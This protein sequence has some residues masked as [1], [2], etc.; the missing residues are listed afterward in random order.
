MTQPTVV[1]TTPSG[2]EICYA[3]GAE[4]AAVS[5]Q[6]DFPPAATTV[7]TLTRST[8]EDETAAD[9][10]VDAEL[11]R[12]VAPT[13]IVTQTVCGVCAVDESLV[14]EHLG[15]LDVEPTVVPLNAR[16]LADVY[17]CIR[18]VGRTVG[19]AERAAAVVDQLRD[20]VT[21]V[22]QLTREADNRP[23]VLVLEWLDPLR[24][25]GNWVPEL[26]EA[27]GGR[28][29]AAAAGE[30]SQPVNWRDLREAD[31][32]VI[33][34]APCGLD[35]EA[36]QEAAGALENRRGWEELAAVR[37]G[38]AFALDGSVLSRWTP[39]LGG[40][41]ERLASLLHPRVV[42]ARPDATRIV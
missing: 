19:R 14:A 15:D 36:A 25:A 1:S 30:R 37:N 7:P 29:I 24:V 28:P 16:D 27:A 13:V 10:T 5:H 23:E 33:V 35:T 11:L 39:R 18:A 34:V 2:T 20:C 41:L 42:G 3:V 6:C 9:Y 26:V 32:D 4:P 8:S 40:E 12:Q 31:P 21:H 17:G 38:R 22:A